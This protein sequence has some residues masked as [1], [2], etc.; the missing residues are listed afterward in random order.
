[1]DELAGAPRAE[2]RTP[3][4]PDGSRG[5]WKRAALTAVVLLVSLGV[6]RL[7]DDRGG[8]EFEGYRHLEAG[9]LGEALSAFDDALGHDA[10]SLAALEGRGLVLIQMKRLDEALKC[11]ERA[12]ELDP[13][14]AEAHFNRAS[15][16]AG[17]SI[18][19]PPEIARRL[20][21]E[22]LREYERTTELEPGNAGAHSRAGMI[23]ANL[24][25]PGAVASFDRA[26]ELDPGLAEAH[27]FRGLALEKDS[28]EA[29]LAS[30]DR[31]IVLEPEN[32]HPHYWRALVL[33][34]L[35]RFEEAAPS[36]DRAL[37]LGAAELYPGIALQVRQD[38]RL[39][40]TRSR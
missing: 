5:A 38:I 8:H 27:Y 19:R 18:T 23:R 22:A 30:F 13:D 10:A 1:M 25:L 16:L 36:M 24:A 33:H 31:A 12:L 35:G 2:G 28:P 32:P 40:L 11:F 6:R 29:A 34:G 21:E 9:E 17:L 20:L 4:K 3:G 39:G 26:I 37:D 15:V 7:L 14:L